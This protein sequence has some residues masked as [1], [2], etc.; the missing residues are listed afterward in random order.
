MEVFKLEK[1]KDVGSKKF[2]VVHFLDFKIDNFVIV[3]S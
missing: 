1:T 3:I 2:V